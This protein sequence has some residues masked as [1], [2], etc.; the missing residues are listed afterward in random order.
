[1]VPRGP[2]SLSS[3]VEGRNQEHSGNEV[4]T[5]E[6]E[7][8]DTGR[9]ARRRITARATTRLPNAITIGFGIALGIIA[10]SGAVTTIAMGFQIMAVTERLEE[11]RLGAENQ[12]QLNQSCQSEMAVTKGELRRLDTLLNYARSGR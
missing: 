6:Q 8:E 7:V 3:K 11:V 5:R 10:F 4:H 12:R 1:M 9:G 2:V